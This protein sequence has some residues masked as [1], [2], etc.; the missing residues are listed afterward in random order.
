MSDRSKKIVWIAVAISG[1]ALVVLLAVF[2]LFPPNEAS[3]SRPFDITGRSPAKP[4]A[5]DDFS[6]F[7]SIVVQTPEDNSQN[8]TGGSMD[9]SSSTNPQ[10]QVIVVPA[11]SSTQPE[12]SP[13]TT[14]TSVPTTST[15]APKPQPSAQPKSTST[16]A[17]S[18]PAPAK[19][20]TSTSSKTTTSTVQKDTTPAP[21]ASPTTSG[22]FWIQVGSFSEKATADKLRAEFNARGMTA[23]IAV[24][25]IG[26]KSF[27]QVKVGPYA[28][29]TEAKKWLATVK[30]VHGASQDAFVTTQ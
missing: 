29:S 3:Q 8:Q 7:P 22:D 28:S 25:Q 9:T 16:P 26:G 18:T 19:T 5:P 10:S 13:K 1:F 4:T 17:P 21:S 15:P 20:S 30:A 2:F 12:E 6:A 27:Y 14:Q 11:P 23:I 24:K